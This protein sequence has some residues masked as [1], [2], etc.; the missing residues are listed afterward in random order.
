MSYTKHEWV[1]N[2]TITAAK[3]NN[4]EDGIEEAAQSG[5]G[6]ALIV[7]YDNGEGQLDK[8]VKEIYDA[9]VSG[10]PVYLKYINGTPDDTYT[11]RQFLAPITNTYAYA[12][13]AYFRVV[14][15]M[16]RYMTVSPSSSIFDVYKPAV[17]IFSASSINSYPTFYTTIAAT[18]SS[19]EV[20]SNIL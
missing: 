6:G 7:T 12:Y 16:P 1:N 9:I 20:L 19:V 4:I 2:E 15:N 3:M 14:A 11:S 17:V 10:T 18:D 5:G 13:G 8:T